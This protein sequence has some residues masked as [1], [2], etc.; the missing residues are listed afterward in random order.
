MGR[1]VEREIEEG[2]EARAWQLVYL[3]T[4]EKLVSSMLYHCTVVEIAKKI[5]TLSYNTGR[6]NPNH[7]RNIV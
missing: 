1:G 3:H 2:K 4:G 5:S 7:S 6:P